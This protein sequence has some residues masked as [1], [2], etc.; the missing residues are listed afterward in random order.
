MKRHCLVH[1]L[2]LMLGFCHFRYQYS[3]A[4]IAIAGAIIL[5]ITTFGAVANL[6][7][8]VVVYQAANLRYRNAYDLNAFSLVNTRTAR[9]AASPQRSTAVILT[10]TFDLRFYDYMLCLITIN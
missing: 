10:T 1:I 3:D 9:A 7:T 4:E 8:F 2:L 5:S 6:I